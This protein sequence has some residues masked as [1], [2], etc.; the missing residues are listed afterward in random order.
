MKGKIL[1][2]FTVILA[3]VW[4][5]AFSQ[6]VTLGGENLTIEVAGTVTILGNF[7]NQTNGTDGSIDNEGVIELTGDWTNNA[8]ATV[9]TN[10]G[11]E[12]E[13]NGTADQDITGT[14]TTSFYDLEV[15]KTTGDLITVTNTYDVRNGLTLTDGIIMTTT[16]TL[17][18]VLDGATST[19]GNA[20][21]YVDGPI[22]KVGDNPFTF[23]TG[24][25]AFWAPIAIPAPSVVTDAFTAEYFG[26]DFG[27][28]S[29]DGTLTVSSNIE[30][31]EMERT[32]GTSDITIQL[33]W[34][35]N[36]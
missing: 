15:N 10:M 3:L 1:I 26:V 20:S 21:S 34:K 8:G 16:A 24:D 35:D 22:R 13:F 14:F 29:V 33:F 17:L 7:V 31:W 27:D 9:F 23:P 18:I 12:V 25:G 28:N 6:T 36:V 2:F 30:Y 32:A 19:A 4:G 5:R 11:G